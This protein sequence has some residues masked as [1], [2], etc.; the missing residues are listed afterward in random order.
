MQ[1]PMEDV[2]V[3][4]LFPHLNKIICDKAS[5]SGC[6]PFMKENTEKASLLLLA[7]WSCNKRED[8]HQEMEA[9][10]LKEEKKL[11]IVEVVSSQ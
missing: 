2:N 5:G 4:I 9:L 10:L 8:R 1:S 6:K 7:G 11:K 3:P